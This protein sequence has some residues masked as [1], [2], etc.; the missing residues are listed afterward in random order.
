MVTI[1]SLFSSFEDFH[2]WLDFTQNN[3]MYVSF[4]IFKSPIFFGFKRKES[5][6][7][8]IYIKDKPG[9]VLLLWWI[10][11]KVMRDLPSRAEEH[12][13]KNN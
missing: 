10:L 11:N 3:D 5:Q 6:E 1:L 13:R 12:C 7:P 2:G 8:S 4:T 9:K